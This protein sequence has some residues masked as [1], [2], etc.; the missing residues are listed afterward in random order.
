MKKNGL[1]SS[2]QESIL[3]QQVRLL[4]ANSYGG[5]LAAVVTSLVMPFIF[6][7]IVP[8]EHLAVWVVLMLAFSAL[9]FVTVRYYLRR[10][11]EI[12]DHRF[13]ARL[14]MVWIFFFGLLIGSVGIVFFYHASS[15]LI[16]VLIF[17]LM[18]GMTAGAIGTMA[19]RIESFVAFTVPV[20]TPVTVH[21]M[22]C[23]SGETWGM[24][25]LAAVFYVA[26]AMAARRMNGIIAESIF[27]RNEKDAMIVELKSS[28][29]KFAKAFKTSAVM[30]GIISSGDGVV[31]E[32]NQG[33]LDHFGYA[34]EEVIGMSVYD[35]DIYGDI[36]QRDKLLERMKGSDQVRDF[37]FTYKIASGAVRQGVA[38]VNRIVIQNRPCHI[39]VLSDVT[40]SRAHEEALRESRER[41][42][43]ATR[44]KSNFLA[45]M[46]HEIRTPMNAIIGMA[47]LALMTADDAER[48]EYLDTIREA[49]QVLLAIINDIL[50][51]SKIEAGKITLEKRAFD[52]A[53]AL[54]TAARTF[55]SRAHE[56]G[57]S[58]DLETAPDIPAR[59]MGDPTR[60]VQIVNN[61]LSNAVKFT[62]RGGIVIRAAVDRGDAGSG[63]GAVTMLISVSD[64]GI[65]VPRDKREM[66]FESFTQAEASVTR[67]F[68]GTGLGLAICRELVEMMGGRIWVDDAPAGG[69]VF[70]F[71]IP[72]TL[73]SREISFRA[74]SAKIGRA[75]V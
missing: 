10:F 56:K 6:R 13:W 26:M 73:A 55:R 33:L 12:G 52:P 68:G 75:H 1:T 72:F 15:L 28:E 58:L 41:A 67:K 9:Q 50:D 31:L 71:T 51:F 61:L 21:F 25:A 64:T 45:K 18:G 65:G 24:G 32:A 39:F 30:M 63:E 38:A 22:V 60:L 34:R 16:Q 27:L 54:A 11:D 19:V 70:F 49:S 20:V 23:E 40:E 14:F 2:Q 57:L 74:P 7:N 44:A 53:R 62:S 3:P 43:A 37:E 59:V 17:F 66:I 46:S 8:P 35:L 69:S 36:T 29:E 47:E 5:I 42:E 48:N 4:Y